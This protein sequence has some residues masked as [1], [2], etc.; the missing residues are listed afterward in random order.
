MMA[1]EELLSFI[2]RH[3]KLFAGGAVA[4]VLVIMLMIAKGD[5]RH[6]QK[7]DALHV[8]QRDAEIAKNA[9]NLESIT[10]LTDA[11][12]AKN[13]E[14]EARA[15]AYSDTKAADAQTIADLDKRYA[16]TR[17]SRD[18]LQAIAKVAAANPSCPVPMALSGALEG[19]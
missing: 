7:L 15:R 9:V 8:A 19:L 17:A 5:A 18:A 6:W 14:S 13:A 4:V 3:W 1:V 10:R 16:S 12:D 2:W 11:L